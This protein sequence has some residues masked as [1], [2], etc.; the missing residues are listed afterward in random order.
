MYVLLAVVIS[1]A[2]RNG[3]DT[4]TLT[5]KLCVCMRFNA[6]KSVGQVFPNARMLA[7][8]ASTLRNADL[9]VDGF[10]TGRDLAGHP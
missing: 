8:Q 10:S 1:S 6:C 5:I 3:F 2:T 4:V 9:A 7:G